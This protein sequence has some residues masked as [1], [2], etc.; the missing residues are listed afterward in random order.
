LRAVTAALAENFGSWPL[1]SVAE[2]HHPARKELPKVAGNPR[3]LAQATWRHFVFGAVLGVLEQRLNRSREAEP[4]F[5]PV[6][7]NGHGNIEHA[8]TATA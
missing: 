2:N 3:A 4:P 7:S 6:S 8:A 5:V 1:V